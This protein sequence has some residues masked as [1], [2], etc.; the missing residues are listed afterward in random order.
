M[1]HHC[2]VK[3]LCTAVISFALWLHRLACCPKCTKGSERV[4][5][6]SRGELW[7]FLRL[8]IWQASLALPDSSRAVPLCGSHV[9]LWVWLCSGNAR[10]WQPWAVKAGGA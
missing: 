5:A 8:C 10:G 7:L 3:A 4:C 2:C 9:Q 1:L 6:V